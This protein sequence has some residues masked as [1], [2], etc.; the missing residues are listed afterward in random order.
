[1]AGKTVAISTGLRHDIHGNEV[2][3]EPKV[4]RLSL[5]HTT[6]LAAG[7]GNQIVTKLE[8]VPSEP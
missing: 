1:M 6:T 3:Q 2:L 8:T 4:A 7:T 5:T